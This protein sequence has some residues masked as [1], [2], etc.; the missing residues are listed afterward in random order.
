MAAGSGRRGWR[1]MAAAMAVAGA[2][3]AAA[4]TGAVAGG[5]HLPLRLGKVTTGHTAS[6]TFKLTN[7]AGQPR[8][9][10]GHLTGAS[11]S[12][13]PPTPAGPT[14]CRGLRFMPG[15][16]ASSPRPARAPTKPR[17]RRSAGD[18]T[19]RP[20]DSLTG[21]GV[22]P[23]HLTGPNS[24]AARSAQANL[25]A[26]TSQAHHQP[27]RTA[28]RGGAGQ[29]PSVTGPNFSAD[30]IQRGKPG[31]Q[32]TERHHHRPEPPVRGTVDRATSTGKIIRPTES[33]ARSLRPT[34]TAATRHAIITARTSRGAWRW[35]SSQL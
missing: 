34:R 12:R 1:V 15:D 33:A 31:R 8:P 9:A 10:D 4:N 17:W 21:T 13:S 25:T 26:A 14:A 35:D 18:T 27:A 19:S 5:S 3:V 6:Q 24:A 32:Q 11:A 30:T 20:A 7:W 2:G 23:A 28:R 16:G 29:Q 22:P